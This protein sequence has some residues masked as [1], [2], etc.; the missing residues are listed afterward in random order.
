MK[1]IISMVLCAAMLV[2]LFG[3]EM[4]TDQ[5]EI[6][7]YLNDERLELDIAPRITGG[8]IFMPMKAIY[9]ALEFDIEWDSE[10]QKIYASPKNGTALIIEMQVAN[11]VLTYGRAIPAVWLEDDII[12]DAPPQMMDGHILVPLDAITVVRGVYIDWCED[13]KTVMITTA[14]YFQWV[15]RSP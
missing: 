6:S 14:D 2:G 11:P 1:K 5:R 4:T 10:T 7:V 12:L 3:C 13:T 9:E 15:V 8:H